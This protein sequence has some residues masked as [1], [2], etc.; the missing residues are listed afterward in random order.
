MTNDFQQLIQKV[1][2]LTNA[3]NIPFWHTPH[4]WIGTGLT[5]LGLL[6]SLLAFI[7]ARKAKRAALEAGRTVKIQQTTIELTEVSQGLDRLTVAIHFDEAR[8]MLND[9]TRRLRR[10]ISPFQ[11]DPE[12]KLTI[13]NLK[14]ALNSANDSL[15]KVKPAD[16]QQENLAPHAVYYAIEADFSTISGL[17]ADL[18]GLLL[19]KF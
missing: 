9:L 2:E 16:P 19:E 18:L 15:K 5:L 17:I 11:N 14:E 7:E 8:D 3:I 13:G 4:F 10:T 6:F 1:S 12:L